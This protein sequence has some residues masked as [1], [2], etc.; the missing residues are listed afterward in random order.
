MGGRTFELR[1]TGPLQLHGKLE[2]RGASAARAHLDAASQ[3]ANGLEPPAKAG[4]SCAPTLNF[5]AAQVV[6]T[7]LKAYL[8]VS[9]P[10]DRLR[11]TSGMTS[12]SV[13]LRRAMQDS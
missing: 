2:V 8:A 1:P 5:V 7:A 10:A 6:E 13:G 3:L 9:W 11:K 4:A 12:S